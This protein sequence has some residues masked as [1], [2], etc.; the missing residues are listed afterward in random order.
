MTTVADA[1]RIGRL[2]ADRLGTG[3]PQM[4]SFTWTTRSV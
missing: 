4:R 3:L 1:D 2:V